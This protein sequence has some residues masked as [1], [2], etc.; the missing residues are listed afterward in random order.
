M[1]VSIT[2]VYH[3]QSVY[4]FITETNTSTQFNSFTKQ[5]RLLIC[6]HCWSDED[7]TSKAICLYTGTLI[8][9]WHSIGH[10]KELQNDNRCQFYAWK[11]PVCKIS[12]QFTV[13]F[14]RS[15]LFF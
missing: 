5:N 8:E 14:T 4:L 11:N 13:G 12:T 9:V 6:N 7:K 3:S 10:C 2:I 15:G 1:E